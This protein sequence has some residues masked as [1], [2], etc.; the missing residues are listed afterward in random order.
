MIDEAML[1]PGR[2]EIHL[3]ISLPDEKGRLQIFQIHTKRMIENNLLESDVDLNELSGMTKNYTGAEIEAVC[4]GATQFALF[5]DFDKS[6]IGGKPE[7]GKSKKSGV[8]A[9]P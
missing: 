2:L 8:G 4:R 3:E 7:E 6:Q 1:R 9:A 5:K